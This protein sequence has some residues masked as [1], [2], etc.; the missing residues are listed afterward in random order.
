MPRLVL[1]LACLATAAVAQPSEP[2]VVSPGAPS[3][4]TFAATRLSSDGTTVV[5]SGNTEFGPNGLYDVFRWQVGGD[6]EWASGFGAVDAS[7]PDVSGDGSVIVGMRDLGSDREAFRWS[8]GTLSLFPSFDPDG[9]GGPDEPSDEHVVYTISTDGRVVPGWGSPYGPLK[10]VDTVPEEWTDE[11]LLFAVGASADGATAI[12]LSSPPA[13]GWRRTYP[14]SNATP[15]RV[16]GETVTP[17]PLPPGRAFVTLTDISDDGAVIVG[18]T[19][20]SAADAQP[21]IWTASGVDRLPVPDGATGV[22]TAVS[23]D[24]R[25]A[26]GE[27]RVGGERVLAIWRDGV[28]SNLGDELAALTDL[29]DF[30]IDRPPAGLSFDGRY[31]AGTGEFETADDRRV[32]W[33]DLDAAL[34][35]NTSGDEPDADAGD[36][37]CDTDLASP[38]TQCTL[39]AALT[40]ANV[41]P[42]ANRIGFDLD[43]T[44][45]VIAVGSPLPAIRGPLT[46]DGESQPGTDA[47]PLVR[48]DGAGTGAQT[49]G[50]RIEADGVIVRGLMITRFGRHGIHI[51]SGDGARLDELIVGSDV[52]GTDGLGNGGDGIHVSGG[53]NAQIGSDDQG[54]SSRLLSIGVAV[55]GNIRN[56]IYV[57]DESNAAI[58]R[59]MRA[60]EAVQARPRRLGIGLLNVTAGLIDVLGVEPV[61]RPNGQNGVCFVGVTNAILRNLLIGDAGQNGIEIQASQNIQMTGLR[62]GMRRRVLSSASHIGRIGGSGVRVHQSIGITVGSLNPADDPVQGG[63][64]GGWF[65]DVEDSEEVRVSNLWAG[66]TPDVVAL[67]NPLLQQLRN[68]FGGLRISNSPRV[69]I[70]AMGV[71]T[72]IANNGGDPDQ[73]QAGIFASGAGTSA[74]RLFNAHLGTTPSG[75]AGI[76]NLGSGLHLANGVGALLGGDTEAERV[77]SGSNGHYGFLFENL[78]PESAGLDASE[79]ATFITL[80]ANRLISD[81]V[82][83]AGGSAI[84]LPNGRSGFCLSRVTG[85]RLSQIVAG[86][87]GRHGIEILNSSRIELPSL[88]VGSLFGPVLNAGGV[89]GPQGNGIDISN[90]TQIAMGRLLDGPP[91]SVL[92]DV[93]VNGARGDGLSVLGSSGVFGFGVGIG[94]SP[95]ES[96]ADDAVFAALANGGRGA[97]LN[98]TDDVLFDGF[99]FAG[100][101]A[102]GLDLDDLGTM[103]LINS[104]FG[105]L[106]PDGEPRRENGIT[107]IAA[108][109][110]GNLSLSLNRIFGHGTGL[111]SQGSAVTLDGNRFEGQRTIGDALGDAI[112]HLNGSLLGIRNQIVGSEGAGV[113]IQGD[114]D[115]ALFRLNDLIGTG[116][117]VQV[118]DTQNRASRRGATVIATENWWGDPSGPGGAGPGSGDPISAGVDASG[119]LSGPLGVVV[120]PDRYVVEAGVTDPVEIVVRFASPLVG[121]DALDVTISDERGWVTSPGTFTVQTEADGFVTETVTATIGVAGT[122]AMTIRAVSQADGALSTEA[123][124]ILTSRGTPLALGSD[125]PAGSTVLDVDAEDVYVIGGEVLL[126]PG[127]VTEERGVISD[128][129]SIL[130]Q[131]PL[132]FDHAADEILV[133]AQAAAVSGEPTPDDDVVALSVGVYPNPSRDRAVV[134]L[135][136]PEAGLVRATVHDALGREVAVV[137]EGQARAGEHRVALPALASGVYLVRLVTPTGTVSAPVTVIR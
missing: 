97:S 49:D 16:D 123:T 129:G 74:F 130:L 52:S 82:R 1:L 120:S 95:P 20:S 68:P 29:G 103:A 99:T 75:F 17:L 96:L 119:W 28:F 58:I 71:P 122:S 80:S 117:G 101:Q 92:Q 2:F 42:G 26:V 72:V 38:G 9:P 88:R 93:F 63:A 104:A 45:L 66:L 6:L 40:E 106:G 86:P 46:I 30:E 89:F 108:Q 81:L 22:A 43:P 76:G 55:L 124:V 61:A 14:L 33:A 5:G 10:W 114:L 21:T 56:G 39:R 7:D 64:T 79:A 32:W 135:S 111:L 69:T 13:Q 98:Q 3:Y 115:Q 73:P 131:S 83:P 12:A 24:G 44:D 91:G 65:M 50:L 112:V 102:A 84:P 34:V 25:V 19:G 54:R 48:I 37:V 118:E 100:S 113:R 41:Q 126:N 4:A 107:A 134:R 70:G 27:L 47:V 60:G 59:A 62:L 67:P 94:A 85:G 116:L 77:V 125:A 23:G 53:T 87:S 35:V 137:M 109:G 31:V 110:I 90:S 36:E 121:T 57:R 18:S 136:V 78:T 11:F 105:E 128:F 15:F 127:G 133:P 132:R 8:G 51:V